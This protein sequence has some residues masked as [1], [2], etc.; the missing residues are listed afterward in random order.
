MVCVTPNISLTYNNTQ[1]I[2]IINQLY[3]RRHTNVPPLIQQLVFPLHNYHMPYPLCYHLCY[4]SC[5][6][7]NATP[8]DCHN[9]VLCSE[10]ICLHMMISQ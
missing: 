4:M 7:Y 10:L 1:K 6:R 8:L 2:L 5:H 3:Q 9:S